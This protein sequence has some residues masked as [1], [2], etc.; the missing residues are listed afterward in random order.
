MTDSDKKTGIGMYDKW[1]NALTIAF[2]GKTLKER[3][4]FATVA[5]LSC[6]LAFFFSARQLP[7]TELALD[8]PLA[9][10]LL[11]SASAHTPFVYIG[12]ILGSIHYGIASIPRF[13]AL[14]FTFVLRIV[15]S[16]SDVKSTPE[17]S[18]FEEKSPVKVA[19]CAVYCFVRCGMYLAS[20]GITAESAKRTLATLITAPLVTLAFSLYYSKPVANKPLRVLY[21]FSM[22]FLFGCT[23][24][25]T[26]NITY[27]FF[28][29]DTLLCVFFTLCVAKFGGFA[30]AAV[31][32]LALGYIVSPHYCIAFLLLGAVSSLLFSAGAFSGCGISCAVA[33]ICSAV[34][35]GADALLGIIPEI[36]IACA[37][38]T[39]VIRYAFIPSDFPYPCDDASYTNGFSSDMRCALAE[40]SFIDSLKN[41]SENM[42]EIK[43]AV[44]EV[45]K[46]L[47]SAESEKCVPERICREFCESCPLCTI[48]YDSEKENC[49]NAI[50]ELALLCSEHTG[51]EAEKL[52]SYLSSHCIRLRELTEYTKK[53]SKEVVSIAPATEI[54]PCISY[55]SVSDIIA[56]VYE[57]AETELI[58]DASAER[59]VAKLLYSLGVPFGGVSVMGK[60]SK[61]ILIYGANKQKLK[62]ALP[63]FRKGLNSVLGCDYSVLK[64][65]SDEHSPVIFSPCETLCAESEILLSCK[66]GESVC[67]DTAVTF[68]SGSCF[69]AL[70][71]DGMGS[72]SVASKSSLITAEIIKNLMLSEI[73]EA[74]AIKL[75]GESLAPICDECFS[76]VDLMKL[77]LSNGNASITKNHAAA[78]YI[79]RG[80][81]VF[82]CNASS[83]P[84]GI[85]G[86]ATPERIELKLL[87]GDTVIMVSDGVAT[88]PNDKPRL[89]D[90]IG[91]SASLNA[92]ELAERI[93]S[94]AEEVNGKSD[95]MSVLV[96]KISKAA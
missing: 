69:Y 38:S 1:K 49:R 60:K 66:G 95:D 15:T 62:K 13:L 65:H 91:I 61:R 33:C 10:A 37:I 41:A 7:Y 29:L 27:A 77:D 93:I 3:M 83:L 19:V 90:I 47:F 11:C 53:I 28:T 46:P 63:Q 67:G 51:F 86:E 40:L 4:L 52:P 81:N 35:G 80:G 24:Y 88:D 87:E 31:Y 76:T 34:I 21:E 64:T 26:A 36:V 92:R 16:I 14:T 59:S 25:C 70:I 85:S 8:A 75:A 79:L 23:V 32:G 18:Y 6:G 9:D 73:D 22:L 50:K 82:C 44:N 43:S 30:R 42:K 78:S 96:V 57:K 84:I 58:F 74:L 39:P 20:A 55:S 5:A 56:S 54:T 12:A 2:S 89:T 45:S 48:C 68:K 71:T 94:K 17:K 72:G